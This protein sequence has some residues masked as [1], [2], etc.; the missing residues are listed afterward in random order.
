VETLKEL[1]SRNNI[2]LP[3]PPSIALRLLETLRMEE[4]SLGDIARTIQSD[5]ALTAR[6][7][8]VVNSTFYAPSDKIGSIE[9]A[10]NTLGVHVVKNIALSFTLVEDLSLH[11]EG[12]FDI[13]YFWKRSI[14]AAI[15]A[16][17]FS[18]Y[19]ATDDDAIY[20]A[21][22]LQDLGIL[23]M[24]CYYPDEYS[25]LILEKNA[26][27]VPLDV[28]ETKA[29]GFRHQ[30]LCSEMLQMWGLPENIY[31][32][33]R[34]HH[35]YREAPEQ[36]RHQARILFLS[37]ALSS[38]FSDTES[39]EKM[40]FFSDVI[41]DDLQ[42][43]DTD[44]EALVDRG[45]G[46]IIEICTCYQ[47]PAAEIKPLSTMLQEANESLCDMN[48]SYEKLLEEYRKEKLQAEKLAQELR[49]SNDQLNLANQKLTDRAERDYLT[50]LYNRRYLFEFL[51]G[52]LNRVK[53]YGAC[54]SVMI[55]DIDFFKKVN[56]SYGHLA[57]DLVLK[58]ISRVA[59]EMKRNTDLLA[60]YGG[61]EFV[62]VMPQTD[63]AGA[64]V[65]AER[66]RQAVEGLEVVCDG[67]PIR[68]TISAGL[69][70]FCGRSKD[71]TIVELIDQADQA[72]YS[73]KNSGRNRV[74][75]A[76]QI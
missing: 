52:E 38:I 50:G 56:D 25:K 64:A 39:Y 71:M 47:I 22:L 3:S 60:R 15:G 37:N 13:D 72:L 36:Y 14:I 29:F 43:S 73:A 67:Q 61:E 10:L 51:D 66:L 24:H 33:I 48:L 57:G 69:A 58:E 5:P 76:E 49:I 45:V 46:R 65:I 4:F 41:K 23:I 7:L 9:Q 44:L 63:L 27:R 26:T 21:A 68:K 16:E 1:L 40:R 74:V 18:D 28:L 75:S 31:M 2:K 11:S 17:L 20:V 8:K 19:L 34:Y 6:V 30:D 59:T 62:M 32:P 55:F 54:F 70:S 53:R 12:V 42:M 35:G